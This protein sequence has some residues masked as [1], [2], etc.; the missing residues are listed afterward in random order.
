MEALALIRSKMILKTDEQK[1]GLLETFKQFLEQAG[2]R[3]TNS[4]TYPQFKVALIRLGVKLNEVKSREVF[5]VLDKVKNLRRRKYACA[6]IQYRSFTP[7]E[8]SFV[9]HDT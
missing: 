5:A 8:N 3:Q 7:Q 4:L 1:H 6:L 9:P 2:N